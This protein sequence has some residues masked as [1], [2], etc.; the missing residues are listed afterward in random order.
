M[1]G[2]LFDKA[3]E[4]YA[5]KGYSAT[6]WERRGTL[7]QGKETRIAVSLAGGQTYQL[8]GVCSDD[9]GNL[10]IQL[11][12]ANGK[13]VSEDL[14]DDD[15]PIVGVNR[16]GNY[17]MRVVMVTCSDACDFGVKSFMK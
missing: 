2:E 6:G 11:I 17:T 15:F 4:T 3:A 14:E 8:I 7:S 13:V 12:D 5:E 10:D 16:S 1:V 9:C